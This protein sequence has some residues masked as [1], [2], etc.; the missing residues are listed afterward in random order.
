[1][2]IVLFETEDEHDTTLIK[3]SKISRQMLTYLLV[4]VN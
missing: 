3:S 1:M 2:E 4:E